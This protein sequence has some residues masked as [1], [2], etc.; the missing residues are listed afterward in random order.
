[1]GEVVDKRIAVL[2]TS[3]LAAIE[4]E[5]EQNVGDHDPEDDF[6][7]S[8]RETARERQI[9]IGKA[10]P[11]YRRYVTEVP[12]CQRSA[13]QPM[14]PDPR[15]RVSKRQFDRSLGEWRRRLHEFDVSPCPSDDRSLPATV[16]GRPANVA[17]A[18]A[19]RSSPRRPRGAGVRRG[20]RS[21]VGGATGSAPKLGACKT[22]DVNKVWQPPLASSD[23]C[24][25]WQPQPAVPQSGAVRISLADQLLE[26]PAQAAGLVCGPWTWPL[27]MATEHVEAA[28]HQV[29]PQKSLWQSQALVSQDMHGNAQFFNGETPPEKPTLPHRGGQQQFEEVSHMKSLSLEHNHTEA[30]GFEGDVVPKSPQTSQTTMPIGLATPIKSPK[31]S[32]PPSS[33][34]VSPRRGFCVPETPSPENMYNVMSGWK[35]TRA[36]PLS[37]SFQRVAPLTGSHPAQLC[38]FPTF[39]AESW[40]A[41]S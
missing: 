37:A 21:G 1:M 27:P 8:R 32:T 38:P 9:M 20:A 23:G 16:E 36:S 19:R 26:A 5:D 34:V 14:T 15:A 25:E 2:E 10:R 11:E 39:S 33:I 13:A 12:P 22:E 7:W 35:F 28:W 31:A 6:A 40:G 18:N 24:E 17:A 29:T 3:V 30:F 41:L 4:A